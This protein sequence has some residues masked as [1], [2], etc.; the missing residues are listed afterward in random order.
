MPLIAELGFLGLAFAIQPG[1][2]IGNRC[3]SVVLEFMSLEIDFA[4]FA[5]A[6]CWRPVLGLEALDGC[7]GFDESA[8][9]GE[10]LA[11]QQPLL[12]CLFEYPG[13]EF[14][15]NV[16]TGQ[17]VVVLGKAGMIPDL[18][19]QSQTE[20]PAIEKVVMDLL[21]QLPVAANGVKNHQQLRFQQFFRRD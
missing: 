13:Q 21:N 5:A 2:R 16:G 15:S 18:F 9:N 14:G 3:M 19:I 1:V 12:L 7:P 6:G 10:V 17:S 11:G 20:K 8:V 4:V